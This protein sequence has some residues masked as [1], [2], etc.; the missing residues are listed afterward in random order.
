[1]VLLDAPGTG[2]FGSSVVARVDAPR[3]APKTP[4]APR[5]ARR[6]RDASCSS[7]WAAFWNFLYCPPLMD[8]RAMRS[9]SRAISSNSSWRPFHWPHRTNLLHTTWPV[10][11]RRTSYRM[12]AGFWVVRIMAYPFGSG[13]KITVGNGALKMETPPRPCSPEKASE[14]VFRLRLCQTLQFF[15]CAL[16]S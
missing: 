14:F 12:P 5:V 1:M 2:C 16:H 11:S 10:S 3:H 7:H 9:C 13:G 15:G 8:C 4:R 6:P